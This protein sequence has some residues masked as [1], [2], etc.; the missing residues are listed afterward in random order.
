VIGFIQFF[1]HVD[2]DHC[3]VSS[4]SLA[5]S[6]R[7]YALSA[8]ALAGSIVVLVSP[9]V[10]CSATAPMPPDDLVSEDPQPQKKP[11]TTNATEVTES[12]ASTPDAP[13][14]PAACKT[15]APNNRCGLDPQ[16]GCG[17]NETCEVTNETTGATSCLTA[18]TTTLGRNCTQTGDCLAGFTCEYGACRPYCTTP[19]S[20][21]TVGG[22]D[23][24]VAIMGPDDK[25]IANKNVCTIQC[26][27]R[28]PGPVCGTNACHWFADYYKPAKVSDC[29]FG[30]T[31]KAYDVACTSTSSCLP[32]LACITWPKALN[33]KE[34]Q[35]WCR[36]GQTP[37]D[38]PSGFTCKDY[39][40]ADAPVING[41][42]EGLC[43]D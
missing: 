19:L 35:Q 21:C 7:S 37:T 24:C 9:L 31:V 26:D 33:G 1:F 2:L 18:G 6:S 8:L 17:A 36:I 20:K 38:C 34:C 12:D 29:N 4:V 27:P 15:V 25:P 16:C 22:T 32:G 23:L 40:G 43:Q 28:N 5:S 42:K 39:Y 14:A 41:V 30:G 3:Y 11:P 10:A 13:P